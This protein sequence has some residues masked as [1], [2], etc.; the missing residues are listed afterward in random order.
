MKVNLERIE[1][2]IADTRDRLLVK[3]V[4]S[5]DGRSFAILCSLYRKRIS[6]MGRSFLKNEED[7]DDFVQS[8]MEKTFK[9][10]RQFKGESS[11]S[12]WLTKIAYNTAINAA[13]RRKEYEPIANEEGIKSRTLTP[14]ENQIN[15]ATKEAVREAVKELPEK[16]GICIEL[17]FFYDNSYE[18]ICSITG[19]NMNTVK[20]HIFRAKKILREKL[21]EFYGK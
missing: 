17:Y 11:F 6:A 5:G 4:L 21:K 14:E 13:N 16:Y 10:L 9:S 19:L 12:T 20:S 1:Q 15:E 7:A 18:E 2:T 3:A 8:V